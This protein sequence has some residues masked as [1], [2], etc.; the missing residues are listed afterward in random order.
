VRE[1]CERFGGDRVEAAFY[2]I[3]DRCAEVLRSEG[4]HMVPDGEF[5]DEDFIGNDLTGTNRSSLS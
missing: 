3:I 1:L 2:E 5:V 4:L